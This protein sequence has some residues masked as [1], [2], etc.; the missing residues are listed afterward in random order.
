MNYGAVELQG[1]LI[2][3]DEDRDERVFPVVAAL[4]AALEHRCFPNVLSTVQEHEGTL[5]VVLKPFCRDWPELQ[6]LV[7]GLAMKLSDLIVLDAW[8]TEFV[9]GMRR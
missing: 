6:A 8:T 4:K 7:E 2:Q 1:V 9:E 5:V 3:F